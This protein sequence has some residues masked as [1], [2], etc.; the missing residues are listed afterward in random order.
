[1][2]VLIWPIGPSPKTSTLPP[3]GDAGVLDRLPGGGQ[4]VRV[5]DDALVRHALGLL[6]HLYGTVVGLGDAQKLVL[7]PG[8]FP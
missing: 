8:T 4:D 5:V 7:P 3:L 2:R 1:M 6:G